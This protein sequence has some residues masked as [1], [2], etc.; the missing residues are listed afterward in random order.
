LKEREKV[1]GRRTVDTTEDEREL[2]VE[3][4]VLFEDDR[5]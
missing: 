2:T 1:S 4:E 5:A 3:V